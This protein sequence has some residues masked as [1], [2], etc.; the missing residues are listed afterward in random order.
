[1]TDMLDR[2]AGAPISWGVCEVPG[3]GPMLPADRV[4]RELR[5]VGLRAIELGAPGF[6]PDDPIETRDLLADQGVRLVGGFVPLVLHDA[7]VAG[8]TTQR[9]HDVSRLLA[10]AGAQLFVSAAVVDDGW[11]PRRPLGA[12]EWAHLFAM[13]ERLD[14]ITAEHGLQHVLHP[15][16]GTLVETADDVQRVLHG[17]SVRWCL[18]TGHLTIGGVDPLEFARAHGDRVGHVHLKDVEASVVGRLRAGEL[19]LL[20][21]VE[22][23]LFPPLGRG[24]VPVDEVVR[25]LER[26][27]YQGWYVLE[28]DTSIQGAAPP[29]GE[30]PVR[31]VAT[32]VEYVQR[33]LA[34]AHAA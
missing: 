14:S 23:A 25:H 5:S 7:S 19:T 12:D 16:S 32:S 20:E 17:S 27:G 18:D 1:V 11:S 26:S 22:A 6:F 10:T 8:A 3:W 13:L 33:A 28:Q 15:H 31:D 4:L 2:I 29:E 30:G 34:A 9:A 21:A 24:D